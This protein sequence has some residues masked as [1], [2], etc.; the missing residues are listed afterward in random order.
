MYILEHFE[1]GQDIEQ[2]RFSNLYQCVLLARAM[3]D[4]NDK[5]VIR[6]THMSVYNALKKSKRYHVGTSDKRA[7]Y[8]S[9][10]K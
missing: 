7:V 2:L 3:F 8:I 6:R 10:Q 4:Q 9:I 5:H 1:F